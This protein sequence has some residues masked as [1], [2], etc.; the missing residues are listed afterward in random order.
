MMGFT[1]ARGVTE[2][3]MQTEISGY[4]HTLWERLEERFTPSMKNPPVGSLTYYMGFE[5]LVVHWDVENGAMY[6]ALKDIYSLTS[7]GRPMDGGSSYEMIFISALDS[8]QR[9]LEGDFSTLSGIIEGEEDNQTPPPEM[10]EAFI[11]TMSQMEEFTLFRNEPLSRVAFY[12]GSR[13][14]W[15]I[16]QTEPLYKAT[17]VDVFG[18]YQRATMTAN[19]GLRPFICVN[20]R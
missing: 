14:E 15:W 6:L 18:A 7:F 19:F 9:A 5:W 10:P 13:K 8:F 16:Y 2:P 4:N 1:N 11:P 17:Y 3:D 12:Q 20:M